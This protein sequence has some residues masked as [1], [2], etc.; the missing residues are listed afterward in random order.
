MDFATFQ[1]SLKLLLKK[2]DEYLFMT[3]AFTGKYDLP[4][5]RL[6]DAEYD[7]PLVEGIRREVREELGPDV[8]YKLVKPIFQFRAHP[9][10]D[11]PYIFVTVYEADYISGTICLSS[12]H[13]AYQ[14]IDKNHLNLNKESFSHNEAYLAFKR[15]FDGFVN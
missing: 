7:T 10:K 13:T 14:W 15:Y 2:N 8:K 4:G 12:E 11:K 6:G 5:G 9:K 3:C 1:V